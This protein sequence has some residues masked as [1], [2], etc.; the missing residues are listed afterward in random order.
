MQRAHI[1]EAAEE[2]QDQHGDGE[3]VQDGDG[4][5]LREVKPHVA[6]V[7]RQPGATDT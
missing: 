1:R 6:Q 2:E 7:V 5:A 4:E 3:D